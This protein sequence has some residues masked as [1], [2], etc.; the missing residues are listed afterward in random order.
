MKGKEKLWRAKLRGRDEG[1]KGWKP[2][3]FS[4]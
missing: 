4:S 2:L 3:E 1:V